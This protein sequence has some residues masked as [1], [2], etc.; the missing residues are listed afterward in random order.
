ML[1][2]QLF[3]KCSLLR[4]SP[5][6][7][8][9]NKECWKATSMVVSGGGSFNLHTNERISDFLP[10]KCNENLF[11]IS[12]E[13]KMK[14]FMKKQSKEDVN[15]SLWINFLIF[16]PWH[17]TPVL[18]TLSQHAH[19]TA[20]PQAAVLALPTHVHVHLAGTATLAAVHCLL[21]HAASEEAYVHI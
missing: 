21:G 12:K 7:K 4:T 5:W 3:N 19:G 15:Q 13:Y 18:L 10:K 6:Y 1:Q 17:Q 16:D 11:C 9:K 2:L 14:K 20:L 8:T